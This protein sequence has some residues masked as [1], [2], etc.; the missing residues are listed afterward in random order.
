[1]R[2][3]DDLN[4]LAQHTIHNEEGKAAQ[5]NAPRVSDVRRP[6]LRPLG[7]QVHSTIKLATEPRRRCLVSF[8]VPSL[9]SLGFIGG[10]RVDFYRELGH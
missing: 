4:P 1:M 9:G 5:Q 7:N 6:G 8:A 10:E 2:H 3:G